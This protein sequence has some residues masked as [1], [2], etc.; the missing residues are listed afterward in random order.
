MKAIESG[1]HGYTSFGI[2]EKCLRKGLGSQIKSMSADKDAFLQR[3]N[4]FDTRETVFSDLIR[5]ERQRL[6]NLHREARARGDLNDPRSSGPGITVFL[7]GEGKEEMEQAVA[8]S[9]DYAVSFGRDEEGELRKQKYTVD[10]PVFTQVDE[11]IWVT[12]LKDGR[13][14]FDKDRSK[15]EFS[16]ADKAGSVPFD[17]KGLIRVE[18]ARGDLWVSKEFSEL[19]SV[20]EGEDEIQV[21]E[22]FLNQTEANRVSDL[23]HKVG[24]MDKRERGMEITAIVGI[25]ECLQRAGGKTALI[26]LGADPELSTPL[27]DKGLEM[28]LNLGLTHTHQCTV[29]FLGDLLWNISPMQYAAIEPHFRRF[30]QGKALLVFSKLPR[31]T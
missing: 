17:R 26:G 29:E 30:E 21:V 10:D 4:P 23:R 5:A 19:S 12:K 16:L 8:R 14:Y 18:G 22:L 3:Y 20:L 6:V 13:Y 28:R 11:D 1:I 24:R 15:M 31:A 27:S 25:D 9:R 7:T 2:S